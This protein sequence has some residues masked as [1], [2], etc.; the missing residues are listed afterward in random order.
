[1]AQGLIAANEIISEQ[2]QLITQQAKEIEEKENTINNMKPD[3]EYGQAISTSTNNIL[4]RQLANR[5]CKALSSRNCIML[6]W[7][8]LAFHDAH[9]KTTLCRHIVIS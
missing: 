2:K 6:N 4:V 5:I 9:V 3:A 7:S 8:K 1:M